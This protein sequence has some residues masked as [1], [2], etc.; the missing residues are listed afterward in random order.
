MKSREWGMAVKRDAIA[1]RAAAGER[2]QDLTR[3]RANGNGKL[4][5]ANCE[6]TGLSDPSDPDT[7]QLSRLRLNWTTACQFPLVRIAIAARSFRRCHLRS[8]RFAVSRVSQ[9][10]AAAAASASASECEPKTPLVTPEDKEEAEK[11]K[12]KA[13]QLF[14]GGS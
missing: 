5:T 10:M 3:T 12:E 8:R 6:P 2:L 1:N 11:L 9:T 14:K 7:S 13:N 4:Q